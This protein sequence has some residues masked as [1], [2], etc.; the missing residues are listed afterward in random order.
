[1]LCKSRVGADGEVLG[2]SDRR[3][4]VAISR[5]KEN[6]MRKRAVEEDVLSF[7]GDTLN[8]SRGFKA[9]IGTE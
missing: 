9:K 2:L 5:D 8:E 4:A 6:C 3:G 1:M 7:G